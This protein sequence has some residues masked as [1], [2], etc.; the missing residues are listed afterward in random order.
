ML[1]WNTVDSEAVIVEVHSAAMTA[2]YVAL[3]DVGLQRTGA[4]I[5]PNTT[6]VNAC[7]IMQDITSRQVCVCGTTAI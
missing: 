7:R 5:Q 1:T 3:K 4:P 6:P 2:C